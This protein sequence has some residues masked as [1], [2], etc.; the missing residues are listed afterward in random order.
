MYRKR[1]WVFFSSLLLTT[2]AP[3]RAQI[4]GSTNKIHSLFFFICCEKVVWLFDRLNYMFFYSFIF[5]SIVFIYILENRKSYKRIK[6]CP[7]C[8][9]L[10]VGVYLRSIDHPWA[11]GVCCYSAGIL[12]QKYI[13]IRR[14][15]EGI[16]IGRLRNGTMT[17]GS[18]T[19]LSGIETSMTARLLAL[20]AR[21][22]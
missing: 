9:F 19:M 12:H 10:L 4:L 13:Y 7:S 6:T 2:H 5:F 21:R 17:T 8:C 16:N 18:S 22:Q 15:M 1:N 20:K 14:S 11:D 3:L